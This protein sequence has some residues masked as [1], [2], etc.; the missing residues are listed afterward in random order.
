MALASN[1]TQPTRSAYVFELDDCCGVAASGRG[2]VEQ[3][4]RGVARCASILASSDQQARRTVDDDAIVVL[5]G[6]FDGLFHAWRPAAP[7]GSGR[8]GRVDEVQARRGVR[9]WLRR[10]WHSPSAYWSAPP[11]EN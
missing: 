10:R 8:A 4:E 5:A 3:Q 1:R 6:G 9:L 11:G 7:P 2:G